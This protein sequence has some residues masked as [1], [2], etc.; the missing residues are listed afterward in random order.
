MQELL[1]ILLSEKTQARVHTAGQTA[2]AREQQPPASHAGRVARGRF[3]RPPLPGRRLSG[4]CQGPSG[5]PA[6][7]ERRC[8]R[9]RTPRVGG[10][11]LAPPPARRVRALPV[12]SVRA[13]PSGLP[14]T[15]SPGAQHPPG[16]EAR[17]AR[18]ALPFFSSLADGGEPRRR[19][20]ILLL[21]RGL[22]NSGPIGFRWRRSFTSGEAR[23]LLRT[24]HETSVLRM[25]ARLR[26]SGF[27]CARMTGVRGW[28]T[29]FGEISPVVCRGCF[30]HVGV[31][32]N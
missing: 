12:P 10:A 11:Q 3:E 4:T 16:E 1:A 9:A 32:C 31:K 15:P 29:G 18:A 25:F 7:V 8:P 24:L 22:L 26:R 13:L 6:Q 14:T 20:G 23:V 17:G 30:L 27:V 21:G 19:R 2:R 28:F 5:S